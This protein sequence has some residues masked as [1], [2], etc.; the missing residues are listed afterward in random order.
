[1]RAPAASRK[2]AAAANSVS[3]SETRVTG[4]SF[5]RPPPLWYPPVRKGIRDIQSSAN[6]SRLRVQPCLSCDR[7]G[8]RVR[9]AAVGRLSQT[10]LDQHTAG[11]ESEAGHRLARTV[12]LRDLRGSHPVERCPQRHLP[13][14]EEAAA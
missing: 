8:L 5:D 10:D 4:S 14:Q 12:R 6:E 3:R 13:R 11:V 7:S 1:M 9:H 2:T